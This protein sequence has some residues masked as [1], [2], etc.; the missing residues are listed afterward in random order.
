[1]LNRY[2]WDY[3]DDPI[4]WDLMIKATGDLGMTNEQ[5]F[6]QAQG[7]ALN[8]QIDQAIRALSDASAQEKTGSLAQQR[9][10][11]RIDQLRLLQQRFRHYQKG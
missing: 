4:G 9:Y 6:A 1:M 5:R 7:L 10:D 3:P 2:T 8:G 11:A